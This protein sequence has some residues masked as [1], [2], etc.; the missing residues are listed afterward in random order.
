[1]DNTCILL[2]IIH[3]CIIVPQSVIYG[4]PTRQLSQ[5]P[6]QSL[7]FQIKISTSN[8]L[9]QTTTLDIQKLI[10]NETIAIIIAIYD[11]DYYFLTSI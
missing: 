4:C 2:W 5:I 9:T 6:S 3:A 11:N 1:M 7:G 10:R 8:I